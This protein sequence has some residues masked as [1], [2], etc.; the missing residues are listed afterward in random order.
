MSDDIIQQLYSQEDILPATYL[1]SS[2]MGNDIEIK[3]PPLPIGVNQ[4]VAAQIL[5]T[6]IIAPKCNQ[7]IHGLLGPNGKINHLP[8]MFLAMAQAAVR[9][10]LPVDKLAIGLY[11][12][13]TSGV[14]PGQYVCEM[15]LVIYRMP[16]EK[17]IAENVPIPR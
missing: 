1:D 6:P 15:H 10:N 7:I 8:N 4:G 12:D 13:D 2:K 16:D 11:G 17:E 5:R 9:N 14:L 3:G